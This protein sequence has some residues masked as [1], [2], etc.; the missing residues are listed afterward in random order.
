MKKIIITAIVYV[1][2]ASTA[3]T[4]CEKAVECAE[5]T[6]M[7][8]SSINTYSNDPSKANCTAMKTALQSWLNNSVCAKADSAMSAQFKATIDTLN[9]Q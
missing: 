7:A 6:S 4:S 8:S 3:L 1:A 2:L 9:C 5:L